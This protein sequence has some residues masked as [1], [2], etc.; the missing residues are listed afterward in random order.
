MAA[1]RVLRL[2]CL[3]IA[4]CDGGSRPGRQPCPGRRRRHRPRP[5]RRAG[6]RPVVPGLDHQADD[7]LC[8]PRHGA[9]EAGPRWSSSSPSR[10]GARRCRPRR[11]RSGPGTQIRLDN[12]LKIIMVK[13]A[14]DVAATIAENLGGSVEGFAGMMNAAAGGSACGRATSSI[15]TVCRTSGSR[16]RPGTWRSSPVRSC[17]SSRSR[18]TSSISARSSSAGAIMRNHNGLIGRYPGADG[19][20]T[21]FICASGFN[22]V[23]SA[24]PGRPPADHGR[25]RLALGQRADDEGG[26]SV[27]P[28]LRRASSA[29]FSPTLESPAGLRPAG[30]A[31]HALG[32]LRP[33]RPDARRGGPGRTGQRRRRFGHPNLFGSDVFAFAGGSGAADPHAPLGPRAPVSRSASGSGLN[34][35]SDAELAAQA[36]EEAAEEEARLAKGEEGVAEEAANG[37]TAGAKECRLPSRRDRSRRARTG[38]P[39]PDASTPVSGAASGAKAKPVAAKRSRDEAPPTARRPRRVQAEGD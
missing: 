25:A 29:F 9:H 2:S 10:I 35:P 12:A 36:A 17:A 18:T 11:W 34:P 8:G 27:R 13:S 7:R 39:T 37:K 14:N 31:Q 22:V 30:A 26:R 38:A 32:D 21:G 6:H 23:A 15:R 33:A 24:E 4:A 20:K 3:S 16:P 28:R 19:M 5:S 1:S